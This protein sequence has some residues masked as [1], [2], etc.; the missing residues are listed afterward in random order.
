MMES[1]SAEKGKMEI[2]QVTSPTNQILPQTNTN[3]APLSMNITLHKP[4]SP[5]T[6]F[7][8]IAL[9][10][11]TFAFLHDVYPKLLQERTLSQSKARECHYQFQLN[12]CHDPVHELRTFCS[13]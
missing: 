3:P 13:E 11:L 8:L 7:A 12:R 2:N 5:Y 1:E 6:I 4:T 10:L 9:T